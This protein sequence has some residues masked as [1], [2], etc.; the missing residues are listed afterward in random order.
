[1]LQRGI[2]AAVRRP[3]DNTDRAGTLGVELNFRLLFAD[4]KFNLPLVGVIRLRRF[5]LG[6]RAERL[7][8]Q[9]QGLVRIDITDDCDFH[10]AFGERVGEP[11]FH[12]VEREFLQRLARGNTKARVVVVQERRQA[13]A[14]GALGGVIEAGIVAIQAFAELFHGLGAKSRRGDVGSG[15]LELSF[16]RCRR[17]DAAQD[18]G[19]VANDKSQRPHFVGEN[20]VDFG[21]RVGL[22]AAADENT[23]G[24]AIEAL[25]VAGNLEQ[26]A[27]KANDHRRFAFFVVGVLNIDANV[28]I[29][30]GFDDVQIFLIVTL[31]DRSGGAEIGVCPLG[32]G[33]VVGAG[34]GHLRTGAEGVENLLL[35]VAVERRD[36]PAPR[37]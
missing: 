24:E 19:I 4:R 25:L 28:V 15:G 13:S 1:M 34:D 26:A 21:Q 2:A 36:F 23:G 37:S 7:R 35:A 29:E 31:G 16:E 33:I 5:A 3:A 8:N 10:V 17:A 14:F 22:E 9:L 30:D 18:E 12:V 32:I 6:K 11:G 27:A 20:A